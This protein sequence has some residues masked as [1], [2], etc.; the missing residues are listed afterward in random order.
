MAQQRRGG[1]ERG[2]ARQS[3]ARS[4]SG[5]QGTASRGGLK[6][7]DLPWELRDQVD[8]AYGPIQRAQNPTVKH[9][10]TKLKAHEK[11]YV[12]QG[13]YK[14]AEEQREAIDGLE[15]HIRGAEL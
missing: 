8:F 11:E 5:R 14:T 2:G 12:D 6:Y 10:L 7:R 4:K 15:A 3:S 9:I 13:A 1:L